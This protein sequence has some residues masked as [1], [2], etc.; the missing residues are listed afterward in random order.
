MLMQLLKIW[1]VR[2]QS[3]YTPSEWEAVIQCAFKKNPC[4]LEVLEHNDIID[5][6]NTDAFPEYKEVLADKTEEIMTAEQKVKQKALNESMNMP[7]RKVEKVYWSKIVAIKFC[8]DDPEKIFFKYCYTEDFRCA[9]FSSPK[10]QLRKKE[11]EKRNEHMRKYNKPCG[12][13]QKK[14]DELIKLCS[15]QLIPSRH[16]ADYEALPVN[17]NKNI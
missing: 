9:N 13:S 11:I 4:T 16:H 15:K 3:I 14:K 8:F 6:K 7:N 17:K 1:C 2:R 12:I 5:F 10:R